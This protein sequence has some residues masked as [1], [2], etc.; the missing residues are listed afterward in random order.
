MWLQLNT[1]LS[2]QQEMRLKEMGVMMRNGRS[3]TKNLRL[4]KE[5][6]R[7]AMNIMKN[8]NF[9]RLSELMAFYHLM[10]KI[11]SEVLYS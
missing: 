11:S 9:E 3:F 10:G 2:A 8:M 1:T 7:K 6:S 4:D 5:K